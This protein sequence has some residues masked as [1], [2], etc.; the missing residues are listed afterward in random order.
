[1]SKTYITRE[2]DPMPEPVIREHAD[3]FVQSSNHHRNRVLHVPDDE[4]TRD[5]PMPLC[6]DD[7]PDLWISKELGVF[8]T[9]FH[10]ICRHCGRLVAAR[11]LG[12]D[13]SA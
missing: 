12:G 9:G 2:F 3:Y 6:R 1:M 4:S 13:R 5:E 7:K 10:P 8:P 11:E